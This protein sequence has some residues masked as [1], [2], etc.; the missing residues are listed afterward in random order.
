MQSTA[1][2]APD[3]TIYVGSEDDNLYAIKPDGMKKWKFKTGGAIESSPAIS[4]DG[5][6]YV[7]S[8]DSHLYAVNPNGSL[9]W[10]FLA[11]AGFRVVSSPAI[12]ADGTVYVGSDDGSLYALELPISPFS[13]VFLTLEGFGTDLGTQGYYQTVD[14]QSLRPTLGA[15]WGTNGFD[16]STGI[17]VGET[18]TAYLNNN[19]LG[20]GRDMHCRQN[21]SNVACYVTNYGNPDQDP[22]NAN[23]AL[24]ADKS[25]AKATVAMEYSAIEGQPNRIVKFF[26]FNG[27]QSTA[28]RVTSADLDGFGEKFVPQLCLNCHGGVYSPKGLIPSLKEVDMGS[29]FREFDLAS[30]KYPMFRARPLQEQSFK[31]LNAIVRATNPSAAIKELIDGWYS[32]NRM[33]QNSSFVPNGWMKDLNG[34]KSHPIQN[35]YKVVVAGSCR[36]CHVALDSVNSNSSISWATYAQFQQSRNAILS[37]VCDP[38]SREMPHALVTFKNFWLTPN[39]PA[40]LAA[41]SD[42]T[43]WPAFGGCK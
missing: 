16:P 8:D 20:F 13:S 17:G 3:G 28:I 23:L 26:V 14:P 34:V 12:G 29:S 10:K 4:A 36:T 40:T 6:I 19:D 9:K 31:K 22:N 5:T 25:K 38:S 41:F 35:L 21:G 27:G 15:W 30:F 1:A 32:P 18:R 39:R 2:I 33:T 11:D 7:G 42:G 24:K 43:N 37:F